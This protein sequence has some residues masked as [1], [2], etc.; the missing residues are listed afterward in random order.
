M[1][2]GGREGGSLMGGRR[3][4]TCTCTCTLCVVEG[5]KT[6]KVKV[7]RGGVYRR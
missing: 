3:W 2:K 4:N 6:V 7:G 1:G 5:N